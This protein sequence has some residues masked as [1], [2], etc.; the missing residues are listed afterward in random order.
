MNDFFV[1]DNG[2][3]LPNNIEKYLKSVLSNTTIGTNYWD[4]PPPSEIS[5]KQI[6]RII[7]QVHQILD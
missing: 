5:L 6:G 7:L 2:I 3:K 4:P 1:K